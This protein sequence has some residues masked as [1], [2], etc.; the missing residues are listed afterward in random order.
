MRTKSLKIHIGLLACLAMSATMAAAS[1]PAAWVLTASTLTYHVSDPFHQVYGVSHAARGKGICQNGACQF[2]AAAPV[3]SFQSG[4]SNRDLHMLQTVRGG[5]YPMVVVRTSLPAAELHPG[6]L[7]VNLQIQ[8]AGHAHIYKQ[9]PFKV[10]RQGTGLRLRGTIP[11]TLKDFQIQS[12]EF[13][14]IKIH[15][16]IPVKVDMTWQPA[17]Q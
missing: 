11:A 13:L 4:D 2:L 3:R 14:W 17:G 6:M 1:T 8:F 5:R 10:T 9:V 15:N 12:P 7:R 16:A